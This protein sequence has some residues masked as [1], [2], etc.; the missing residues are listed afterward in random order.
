M[1]RSQKIF[2]TIMLVFFTALVFLAIDISRKTTFPGKKKP[3]VSQDSISS[4]I[5][6]SPK[7]TS[8]QP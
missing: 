5:N 1:K 7:S 4:K 2:I 6:L 3:S 8:Q